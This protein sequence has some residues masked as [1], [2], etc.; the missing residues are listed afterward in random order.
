MNTSG[1]VYRPSRKAVDRSYAILGDSSAG[2]ASKR[3]RRERRSGSLRV[4]T[5]RLPRL[6]FTVRRLMLVVVIGAIA[7]G[8]YDTG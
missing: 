6:R 2:P 8:A 5:M 4:S 1:L 7:L 3:R